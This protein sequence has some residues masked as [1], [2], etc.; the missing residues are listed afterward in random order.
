MDSICT[1]AF[2]SAFLLPEALLVVLSVLLA[3]LLLQRFP[4]LL[5]LFTTHFSSLSVFYTL[6]HL[7]E[8]SVLYLLQDVFFTSITLP[9]SFGKAF[10]RVVGS[11]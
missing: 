5:H 4:M 8:V 7:S 2:R 6:A 10:Q 3:P 9:C 1:A 11:F